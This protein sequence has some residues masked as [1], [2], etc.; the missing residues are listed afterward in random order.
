M[1]ASLRKQNQACRADAVDVLLRRVAMALIDGLI[2]IACSDM[3]R[4]C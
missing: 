3:W 4:A 1:S 2:L